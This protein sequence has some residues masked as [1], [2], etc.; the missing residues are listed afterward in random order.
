MSALIFHN[1]RASLLVLLFLAPFA[2]GA[3]SGPI[4]LPPVDQDTAGLPGENPFTAQ[5][6][7]MRIARRG[8]DE[9]PSPLPLDVIG[10]NVRSTRIEQAARQA[11]LLT[12]KGYELAGRGAFFAARAQFRAALFVLAQALDTEHRTSEH[13]QMLD[14]AWVALKEAEDFLPRPGKQVT[15]ASVPG[16]IARHDSSVLKDHTFGVLT[17]L[18]AYQIYLNFAQDLFSRAV[19]AEITGSMALRGLGKIYAET[20]AANGLL[21]GDSEAQAVV[22]YQ[23]ALNVWPENYMAAN[24][25]GVLLARGGRWDDAISVLEYARRIRN[26]PVIVRNL[27]KVYRQQGLADRAAKLLAE[28]G[29]LSREPEATDNDV[30][31]SVAWVPPEV[32]D[33][34]DRSL[35]KGPLG[36]SQF[37]SSNPV[38][39]S[40]SHPTIPTK[41]N[42]GRLGL[43]PLLTMGPADSVAGQ[44]GAARGQNGV[45]N[46]PTEFVPGSSAGTQEWPISLGPTADPLTT[47]VTLPNP[48]SPCPRCAVDG[49][50][51]DCSKWG[52]WQRARMIA[53]EKYAQGEYVGPA[54]LAHVPEYR[55]RV[56]D[57]LQ[58]VYRIT[59]EETSRPYRLN[60]GDQLRIESATDP[61]LNR[62][63]LIQPDGTVTL[64]LLGQVKATGLTV[65]QLRDR[66]EQ[67]YRRYYRAPAI[68]VTPI[69]V[70]S[71]LE[72]LRATVDRRAGEG[73]QSQNV[74]I[75]PEGTIAL[76]GLGSVKAQG[77]TLSELQAELNERYREE[78]EGIEAMPILV[79]RAPRY[80]YVLGEV[81]S[82]GRFELTGP[83]TVIQAISMAGGWKIGANLRQVVI[84]RR[85]DDWRLLATMLD[86][87]AALHGNKATPCDEIWLSDSDVV[88]VPKSFL[89]RSDDFIEMVFT[90]GIYGVLPL[91]TT[92]NFSKLSTI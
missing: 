15:S 65:T 42:T 86:L 39:P 91:Q 14:A 36:E 8:S 60:V 26:D 34:A 25:L 53:W 16:I 18:E 3:D 11:D 19:A 21:Q 50:I 79:Q 68:T 43:L 83:T 70:N 31:R 12:F 77:L 1:V 67:L 2:A 24:D 27:V 92:I 9:V 30:V 20:S 89:Q 76:P 38:T 82:P 46:T 84:F 41:S 66:L 28:A 22:F 72:D 57:E 40:G 49:S 10:P 7:E 81:E 44:S 90:R 71:K 13:S 17:P 61:T 54:R 73:G 47:G 62:D 52:G 85:G 37:S 58:I 78:V 23:A 51:C 6:L 55:L 59:R 69:L 35:A 5:G 45:V 63:V 74:R 56:D 87:Q 64:L 4:R 48:A 80:V 75:T 88:I 33:Q 32:L 29:S